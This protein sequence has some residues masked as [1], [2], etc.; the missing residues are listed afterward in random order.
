[1][2][3]DSSTVRSRMSTVAA[4]LDEEGVEGGVVETDAGDEAFVG[5]IDQGGT[6]DFYAEVGP[7]PFFVRRLRPAEKAGEKNHEAVDD[8]KDAVRRTLPMLSFFE[9]LPPSKNDPSRTDRF[10][11]LRRGG[12]SLQSFVEFLPQRF[13]LGDVRL[14][15]RPSLRG[16]GDGGRGAGRDGLAGPR[17]PA[18]DG[19]RRGRRR[20]RPGE[21]G[22]AG[23]GH[24]D[25]G[26]GGP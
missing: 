10:E 1:M 23:A 3:L 22:V 6:A 8:T 2:A 19:A 16:V 24:A 26:S 9:C 11:L 13:Q 21:P 17:Q 14:V 5:K 4:D 25:T 20:L 12:P 7:G 15:D 18:R